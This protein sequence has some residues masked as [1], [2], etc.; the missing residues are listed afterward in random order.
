MTVPMQEHC[1]HLNC[2]VSRGYVNSVQQQQAASLSLVMRH[3]LPA[4]L[5]LVV[6]TCPSWQITKWRCVT[7][8]KAGHVVPQAVAHESPPVTSVM[9]HGWLGPLPGV[10]H[11]RCNN[12]GWQQT[13]PCTNTWHHITLCIILCTSVASDSHHSSCRSHFKHMASGHAYGTAESTVSRRLSFIARHAQYAC[14]GSHQ[15]HNDSISLSRHSTP[16]KCW[17]A[18]RQL[19]KKCSAQ[20]ATLAHPPQA[21]QAPGRSPTHSITDC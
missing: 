11:S 21:R 15:R 17:A 19:N 3:M 13:L 16:C 8:S 6:V 1:L 5:F 18:H 14:I 12:T 9:A 4:L 20:P 10:E 2:F 7:C